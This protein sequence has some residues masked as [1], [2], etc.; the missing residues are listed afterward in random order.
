VLAFEAEGFGEVG[1]EGLEF[2]GQAGFAGHFDLG[3]CGSLPM[4]STV[5]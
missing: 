1:A 5:R 3:L 4:R 2:G